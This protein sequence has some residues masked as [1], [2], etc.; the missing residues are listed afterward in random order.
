MGL[1]T[2]PIKTLDDLFVHTLQD[3]YYA[4]QKI[5]KALPKMIEKVTD[6]QLKQAF[7]THLAETKNQVRRLEQVFE[8]HGEPAKA[9][10]CPAIDGIIDEANEIMSDASDPEVLDAAALASAQ[11]VEHYEIT[12]YGTLIAWARQL[13][14]NDCASVLQQ[15]L[16]EEKETDL[17]LTEIA[18]A[19]VNR[20]AV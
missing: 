12:R 20:V 4:E 14:R 1:L 13:G 19:Q 10:T 3:V 6:P 2:K 16:E 18:E 5:T 8:M 15:T 7:Q 11:A 9:V 17:R